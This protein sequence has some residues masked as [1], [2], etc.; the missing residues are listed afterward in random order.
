MQSLVS[1]RR[2]FTARRLRA[3]QVGLNVFLNLIGNPNLPRNSR[4]VSE[5][6]LQFATKKASQFCQGS[7]LSKFVSR[8][9]CQCMHKACRVACRS[10][11]CNF[12]CS[13]DSTCCILGTATNPSTTR[14]GRW[15]CVPLRFEGD[16]KT[17]AQRLT[18]LCEILSGVKD[19]VV[20]TSAQD[21]Q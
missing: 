10:I 4:P 16:E 17:V 9:P 7:S 21:N 20:A 1:F 13:R 8:N 5:A 11:V 14:R 2:V 18:G 19:V 6:R 15:F 12:C 3:F